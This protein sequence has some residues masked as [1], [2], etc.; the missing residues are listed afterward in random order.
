MLIRVLL[1]TG[2]FYDAERFA[3][4]KYD[5]DDIYLKKFNNCISEIFPYLIFNRE[6]D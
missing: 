1:T 5:H 6:T 2:D 3:E 4:V